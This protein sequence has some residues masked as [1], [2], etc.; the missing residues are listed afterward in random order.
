MSLV[1]LFVEQM[2]YNLM[3]CILELICNFTETHCE[4]EFKIVELFCFVYIYIT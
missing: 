4:N 3:L 2:Q 1:R